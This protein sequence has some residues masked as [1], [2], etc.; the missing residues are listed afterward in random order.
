[1][2]G[3]DVFRQGIYVDRTKSGDVGFSASFPSTE[4][5]PLKLRANGRVKLR[6]LVDRS[7][8]EVFAD[9]GRVDRDRPD[10]PGPL[11]PEDPGLLQRWPRSAERSE[12]LAAEVDLVEALTVG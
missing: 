3:Y 12:D 11:E 8:V 7:S 6:I 5:A 4:F 9:N 10:L 1:M 2:I